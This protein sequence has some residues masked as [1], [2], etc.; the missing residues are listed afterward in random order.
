MTRFI[1]TDME[2]EEYVYTPGPL[3]HKWLSMLKEGTL[4]AARCRDGTLM[5]PPRAFCDDFSEAVDVVPISPL[6][7]V[8][9][10]TT[11]YRDFYGAPLDEPVRIGYIQFP[12]VKGGLVHYVKG[13]V[14]IGVKVMPVWR[15]RRTGSVTDIAYFTR[16]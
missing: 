10:L 9:A 12:G 4:G 7:V 14:R 1:F 15:E 16:A 11:I 8:S 6:G 2:I 3:G 13:D 5:L